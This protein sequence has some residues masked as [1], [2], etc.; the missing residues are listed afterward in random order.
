MSLVFG[1]FRVKL[2]E[3]SDKYEITKRVADEIA[4]FSQAGGGQVNLSSPHA[5]STLAKRIVDMLYGQQ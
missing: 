5:Q 1:E 2:P 4:R 3:E